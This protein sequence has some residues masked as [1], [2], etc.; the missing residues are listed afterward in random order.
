MW[1][2]FL[3][4][5][6]GFL[7]TDHATHEGNKKVVAPGLGMFEKGQ[8]VMGFLFWRFAYAACVEYHQVGLIHVGLFPTQFFEDGLDALGVSLVHLAANGPDVIF[9]VGDAGGYGHD[10]CSSPSIGSVLPCD[11]RTVQCIL[12]MCL[13]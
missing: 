11:R 12:H 2:A 8:L 4:F 6:D 3:Q 9:P 13:F 7:V 10:I 5:V 1:V